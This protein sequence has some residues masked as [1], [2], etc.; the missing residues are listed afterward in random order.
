MDNSPRMTAWPRRPGAN[1]VVGAD[2]VIARV[3]GIIA[4]GLPPYQVAVDIGTAV[5]APVIGAE[6]VGEGCRRRGVEGWRE[7]PRC[8]LGE[9]R[10]ASVEAEGSLGGRCWVGA[11][12]RRRCERSPGW[13]SRAA[14]PW[15]AAG[16]AAEGD[17][18]DE[19]G[20]R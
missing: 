11:F 13:G 12:C 17:D 10:D 1:A 14:A 19:T 18:D 5:A 2:E 8:P 3:H 4:V 15:M 16:V 6:R 20:S 9:E 7:R